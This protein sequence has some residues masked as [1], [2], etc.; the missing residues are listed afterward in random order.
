MCIVNAAYFSDPCYTA[1]FLFIELCNNY[2]NERLRSLLY[3]RVFCLGG[4]QYMR[5]YIASD[6]C[7]TAGFLFPKSGGG[8]YAEV[9]DPC[10]TAGFLFVSILEGAMR[11]SLRSLLYGGVFV[12]QIIC[13][14]L[15]C[16]SQIPAV[17]RGF[18]FSWTSTLKRWKVSD[19]CCTA[20]FLFTRG[21]RGMGKR[22]LRSLLYGG[23]FVLAKKALPALSSLRSLLYGGVFVSHQLGIVF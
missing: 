20:G 21:R 18:C 17:R 5:N 4:G 2:E 10:C 15:V 3:G 12:Y 1:G 13:Q 16:L 11:K 8:G 9:S 7:C 22:G 14:R 23:V 6:P 19:P